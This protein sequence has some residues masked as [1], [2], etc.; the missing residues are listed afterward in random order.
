M[1]LLT[2]AFF[3]ATGGSVATTLAL[4]LKAGYTC[5]ALVRNPTK[6][7][8]LLTSSHGTTLQQIESHLTVTKGDVL[9]RPDVESVVYLEGNKTVDL[10]ISGIGSYP[11]FKGWNPIPKIENPTLCHDVIHN[12]ISTLKSRGGAGNGPHLVTIG[13]TGISNLGRDYPLL[14]TLVYKVLLHEAHRDKGNMENL[15]ATSLR[16]SGSE[17]SGPLRAYTIVHA[18]LLTGGNM[19]GM[20]KVR[21]EIEGDKWSRNAIGYTIS[22]RDVGNWIFEDVIRGFGSERKAGRIARITY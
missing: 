7:T 6:L 9:S 5:K 11:V 3:G 13:T 21:S 18:S 1:S 19:L 8:E 22:R 15:V 10:I 16:R 14:L 4:S 2:I 17:G 20:E 12:L